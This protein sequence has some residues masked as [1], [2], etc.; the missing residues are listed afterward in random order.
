MKINYSQLSTEFWQRGYTIIDNLFPN[1]LL[2]EWKS[3]VKFLSK[4]SLAPGVNHIYKEFKEANLDIGDGV[5]SYNFTSLDGRIVFEKDLFPGLEEY[6]NS[7]ANFLS[8]LLNMDIVTSFD[9]QS[10]ISMMHYQPPGGTLLPHFDT[11]TISFLLYLTD[12]ENEGATK[13]Y[14]LTSLRPTILGQPDKIIN[15]PILVYPKI[16]RCLIFQGRRVW[17]ESLPVLNSEKI[18]SVWNYYAKDD[19]ERNKEVSARLYN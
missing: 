9:K 7:T 18:S 14:P 8:L 2:E 5:G 16:N 17:H 12:N 4:W 13:L 1:R 3:Q 6:Y 15:E 10:S 11:Q 19:L